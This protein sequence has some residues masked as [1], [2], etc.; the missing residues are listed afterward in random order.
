MDLRGHGC[1]R[2]GCPP[3]SGLS[4]SSGQRRGSAP[5]PGWGR[6]QV[7]A[8]D[9]VVISFGVDTRANPCVSIQN[10]I[11]RI[12]NYQDDSGLVPIWPDC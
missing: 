11:A 6:S 3:I 1:G 4:S 12:T 9:L 10:L 2:P 5:T 8:L 7:I